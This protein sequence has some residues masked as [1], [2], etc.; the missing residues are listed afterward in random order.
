MGRS[1]RGGI[2]KIHSEKEA[3]YRRD[4]VVFKVVA[5][6]LWEFSAAAVIGWM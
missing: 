4:G 3:T 1:L 5:G 2:E 6:V